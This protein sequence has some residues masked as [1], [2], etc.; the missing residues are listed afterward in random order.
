M[1]L[2]LIGHH[3]EGKMNKQEYKLYLQSPHWLKLRHIYIFD[4]PD[5]KCNKCGSVEDLNLHH[6]NYDNFWNEKPSDLS[7][8][9]ELCHY[10][11]HFKSEVGRIGKI[12]S[13]REL[14]QNITSCK[15]MEA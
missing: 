6:L 2:F 5:V 9:C 8:L 10:Y 15:R 7:V 14:L 3:S 11:T 1:R 12:V 13:M 4:E